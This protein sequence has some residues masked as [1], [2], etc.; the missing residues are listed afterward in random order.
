VAAEIGRNKAGLYIDKV[1]LN[2][3]MNLT[4]HE[5]SIL[6][7]DLPQIISVFLATAILSM[8]PL[9]LDSLQGL[10]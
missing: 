10:Y 4:V 5:L 7:L 3:D 8:Y 6:L 2:T 1:D 9:T